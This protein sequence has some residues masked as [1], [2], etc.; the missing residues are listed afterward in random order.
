MAGFQIV[1]RLIGTA[2]RM[3]TTMIY[4]G[5]VGLLATSAMLPWWWETPTLP[6][7]LVMASFG[8]IGYLGHLALVYALG[9][10]P[11]STLAPYNYCGFLWAILLGLVLFAEMPDGPT[12]A[13]GAIILGAGIYVWHRERLHARKLAA[14]VAGQ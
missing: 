9:Q 7:A 12:L 11:A 1:T 2:D 8:W 4:A 5:A 6:H 3:R 10:A 13:G 14:A